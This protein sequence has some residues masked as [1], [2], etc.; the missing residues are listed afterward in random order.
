[1]IAIYKITDE[2]SKGIYIGYSRNINKVMELLETNYVRTAKEPTNAL[3]DLI[4]E[5]GNIKGLTLEVLERLDGNPTTDTL[6][7][8]KAHYI[9]ML[10]PSLNTSKDRKLKT[11]SP[12]MKL[13]EL[14]VEQSNK[15]NTLTRQVEEL[16][17]II[18]TN[19]GQ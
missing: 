12:V 2:V 4:K 6:Q 16:T 10:Q 17:R 1:M 5:R 11:T 13:T 19:Q 18:K 7:A 15:I 3:Y 14:I 9:T 8:R